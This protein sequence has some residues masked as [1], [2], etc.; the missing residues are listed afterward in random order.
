MR[1]SKWRGVA[2]LFCWMGVALVSWVLLP[3]AL[4]AQTPTVAA[5]GVVN[6]ASLTAPVSPGS[7]A[8]V[9]GTNLASSTSS[10][11]P[12]F[13][14]P[15]TLLGTT[16]TMNGIAVPLT[17]VAPTQI[18]FQVPWEL[19]GQSQASLIVTTGAGALPS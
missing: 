13:P 14:A 17:F 7:D 4:N 18:N 10:G 12:S 6:G 11:P 5:G 2:F 15:T 9:F 16:V 8:A 1:L 3:S 19:A